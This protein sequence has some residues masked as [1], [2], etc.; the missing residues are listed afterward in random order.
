MS[1]S[2]RKPERRTPPDGGEPRRRRALNIRGWV[3]P[4]KPRVGRGQGEETH[5]TIEDLSLRLADA[6]PLGDEDNIDHSIEAK[7]VEHWRLNANGTVGDDPELQAPRAELGE[8]AQHLREC[9]AKAGVARPKL[10]GERDGHAFGEAELGRQTPISRGLVTVTVGIQFK[11]SCEIDIARDVGEGGSKGVV[12]LGHES[13]N[14]GLSVGQR[15]V[16]I[17]ENAFHHR[18]TGR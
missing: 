8:H 5:G 7:P 3:I 11:D 13:A 1:Y 6:L 16:E 14:G 4:D 9:P 17:E 10:V 18:G 2:R 15:A 12:L